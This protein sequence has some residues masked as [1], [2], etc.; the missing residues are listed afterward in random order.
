MN[1]ESVLHMLGYNVNAQE[2]ISQAQRW[3]ILEIAVDENIL[4]RVEICSHLD[5]L[6]NRSKGRK[7]F[8][9]ACSKWRADRNHIIKYNTGDIHMVEAKTVTIRNYR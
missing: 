7:N 8:E 4:T 5:Y 1:Q 2:N 6:I 3:R 9:N